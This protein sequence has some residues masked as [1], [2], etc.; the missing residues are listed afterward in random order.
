V[1]W[2]SRRQQ[3]ILN[4]GEDRHDVSRA[5]AKVEKQ[6][7][8]LGDEL[9]CAVHHFL[10]YRL[11]AATFGGMWYWRHFAGQPQLAN[12][13]QAVVNEHPNVQ[14][15]IVGI[16]LAR[17]QSFQIKIGLDFRMKLLV[18]AVILIAGCCMV[19]AL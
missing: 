13:A 5:G 1:S 17:G 19:C 9:G 11:Q 6:T 7:A 12:Q 10:Q 8:C 4:K 18:G 16:E 3:S 2:T 15:R 14:H